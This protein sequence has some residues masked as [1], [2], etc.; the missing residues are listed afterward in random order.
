M[1]LAFLYLLLITIFVL[2]DQLVKKAVVTSL[3]LGEPVTII[4]SFF[5]LTYVR[6]YGAGFSIL[7][8][9][10]LFLII[11]SIIAIIILGY[12]LLHSKKWDTWSNLAYLLIISGACGNLIDRLRLGYVVDFLDFKIFFYDY[13]VFNIAD[14][15]ITIGC[16]MLI[17]KVL[18]ENRN[19]RN[20]ADS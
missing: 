14:S 12:E 8:N 18:L 5:Y 15:Y 17:I 9:A 7:Q 13:P 20:K 16:F 1:G 11:I 10:T 6:N 4:N 3:L 2:I 19:A